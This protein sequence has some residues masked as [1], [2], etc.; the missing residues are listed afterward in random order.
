MAS[1]YLRTGEGLSIGN[2]T[3]IRHLCASLAVQKHPWACAGDFNMEPEEFMQA[4]ER[5]ELGAVVVAPR[6]PAHEQVGK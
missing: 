1:V 5:E 6:E 4:Q 2:L 3:I